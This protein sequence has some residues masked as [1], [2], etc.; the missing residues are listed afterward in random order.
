MERYKTGAQKRSRLAYPPELR[1]ILGATKHLHRILAF[2]F[3]ATP[4]LAQTVCAPVGPN[5]SIVCSTPVPCGQGGYCPGHNPP[6]PPRPQPR[7]PLPTPANNAPDP[8]LAEISQ[9][10][11]FYTQGNWSAALW[12]YRQAL[13]LHPNDAHIQNLIATAAA[14][15]ERDQAAARDRAANAHAMEEINGL[16]SSMDATIAQQRQNAAATASIDAIGAAFDGRVPRHHSATTPASD[17]LPVLSPDARPILF[18]ALHH[19]VPANSAPAMA[20]LKAQPSLHQ[21]DLEIAR[22]QTALS[23]LIATNQ[24]NSDQHTEWERESAE[25][26]NDAERIGLN[27]VFDLA[28]AH[29][30]H[31]IDENEERAGEALDELMQTD[32]LQ[33]VPDDLRKKGEQL[34]AERHHLKTAAEILRNQKDLDNEVLDRNDHETSS[35]TLADL[36]EVVTKIKKVEDLAGPSNDLIDAAYTIYRQA[37]SLD[38]LAQLD[39]A[40]ERTLQ[41]SAALRRTLKTL[42]A[43]RIAVKARSLPVHN[44]T[45]ASPPTP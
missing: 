37:D 44:P 13:A 25:A 33:P 32:P 43:Q 17:A 23:R 24:V 35:L 36:Y 22:T 4:C 21:L 11:A 12:H 31:K 5:G 26:T 28:S 6:P 20:L 8:A 3:L 2:V 34:I 16:L 14:N 39:L 27:L 40:D 38:H 41:A 18:L 9:G 19:P 15:L 1:C 30:D 7:P 29:V 45:T 42:V 10:D